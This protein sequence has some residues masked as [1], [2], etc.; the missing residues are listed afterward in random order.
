MGMAGMLNKVKV[1]ICPSSQLIIGIGYSIGHVTWLYI[2]KFETTLVVWQVLP[3]YSYSQR[4][5]WVMT[6]QEFEVKSYQSRS[7]KLSH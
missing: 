7:Y 1:N 4:R 3:T 2:S 5:S 6:K